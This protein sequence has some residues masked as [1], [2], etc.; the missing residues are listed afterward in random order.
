MTCPARRNGASRT[1]YSM[2][3]LIITTASSS[4]ACTALRTNRMPSAAITMIGARI[5][6]ATDLC[7][8]SRGR[9]AAGAAPRCVR[10]LAAV[11]GALVVT[12]AHRVRR[13]LH[14]RQQRCEE[15]G[16]LVDQ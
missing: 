16:L 3:R 8:L 7:L 2:A 5:Q 11:V 6:K 15:V 13:L 4:A 14:A 12:E 10:E 1:A 9:W